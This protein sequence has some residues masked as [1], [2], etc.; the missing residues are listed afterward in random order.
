MHDVL[1]SLFETKFIEE[2][3]KPQEIYPVT[4][5]R[6]IFEKLAHSSIMRLS[7]SRWVCFQR[8]RRTRREKLLHN[9]LRDSVRFVSMQLSP[10]RRC[11][12]WTSCLT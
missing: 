7:E 9:S 11:A 10:L 1:K 12:A 6:K 3:F 4:L 5:T 2:L 8:E